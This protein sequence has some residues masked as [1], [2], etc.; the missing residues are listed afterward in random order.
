MATASTLINKF[1]K[2]TGWNDITVTMLGRD[3]EGITELEYNDSKEMEPAMGAG[4]YPIGY[5][6]GN[7]SAK[8]SLTLYKEEWDA[9]Q[10]SLPPGFSVSDIAP[11]PIVVEYDYQGFKMR[12]S[13]IAKIKGRGVGAKQG[14]KNLNNKA[15][16]MILG[17]ILWNI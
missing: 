10:R 14:D 12:D 5:G 17:K 11:F 3:V 16:L 6:E 13:F 7:Y 15:E 4:A 2:L 8:G 9:L 1:G